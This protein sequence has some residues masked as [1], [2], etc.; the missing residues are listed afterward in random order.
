[1]CAASVQ[2]IDEAAVLSAVRKYAQLQES[3]GR[4]DSVMERVRPISTLPEEV[5]GQ[6]YRSAA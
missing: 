3:N 6:V 5:L 4:R 2:V 1:M